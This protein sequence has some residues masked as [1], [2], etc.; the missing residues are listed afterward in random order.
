M[1][2]SSLLFFSL[3]WVVSRCSGQTPDR[4]ADSFSL[5]LNLPVQARFATAD[6]LGHLY[7]ITAT[8]AVE[9]YAPDGRLLTRY[10]NNRLGWAAGLVS[11][12]PAA[13]AAETEV[14]AGCPSG[15]TT[16]PAV[17]S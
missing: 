10:S 5:L 12:R 6:N 9:K 2:I 4:A 13:P 7:L 16:S 15:R 11:S 8:N 14:R 1:R 3:L 17:R